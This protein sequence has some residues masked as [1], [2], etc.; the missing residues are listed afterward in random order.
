M[1]AVGLRWLVFILGC[2]PFVAWLW[3]LLPWF[4]VRYLLACPRGTAVPLDSLV[5]WCSCL[6]VRSPVSGQVC[7]LPQ[8]TIVTL[9]SLLWVGLLLALVRSLCLRL[10]LWAS[11][12]VGPPG[13]PAFSRVGPAPST[14]VP[15]LWTWLMGRLPPCSFSSV[16]LRDVVTL[17]WGQYCLLSLLITNEGFHWRWFLL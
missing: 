1:F 6:H 16:F 4:F 10:T 17:F 7:V 13:C 5:L 2:P 14:W 11:A 8:S 12:C 9:L 3:R 15:L